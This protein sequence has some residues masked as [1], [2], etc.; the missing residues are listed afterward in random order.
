MKVRR[1][2]LHF[3]LFYLIKNLLKY[4]DK[5]IYRHVD[6]FIH[7]LSFPLPSFFH[8]LSTTCHSSL[9]SY[10][11]L[12][13]SFLLFLHLLFIWSR[14]FHMRPSFF[15][16]ISLLLHI[17]RI[18]SPF[19]HLPSFPPLVRPLS[20]HPSL[21]TSPVSPSTS[22]HPRSKSRGF[23]LYYEGVDCW[24]KR[25]WG[26]EREGV[27]KGDERRGEIRCKNRREEKGKERRTEEEEEEEEE[28]NE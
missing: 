21:N 5:W 15:S 14:L 3:L 20:L 26:G 28:G 8:I 2:I 11:I 24:E 9:F 1:V 4:R 7:P 12:I 25:R 10:H 27:T 19:F 23:D 18:H 6:K 22:P 16:S 17:V 13:I